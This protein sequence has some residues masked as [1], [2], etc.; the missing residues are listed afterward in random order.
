MHLTINRWRTKKAWCSLCVELW[1]MPRKGNP[2]HL[3][4]M[5]HACWRECIAIARW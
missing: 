5:H 1:G 2:N 4:R 3:I